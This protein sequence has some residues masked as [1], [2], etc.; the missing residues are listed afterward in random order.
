MLE[1][2]SRTR[3]SGYICPSPSDTSINSEKFPSAE[4][5]VLEYSKPDGVPSG[6]ISLDPDTGNVAGRAVWISEGQ[7]GQGFSY[8]QSRMFPKMSFETFFSCDKHHTDEIKIDRN[9]GVFVGMSR[10]SVILVSWSDP[11]L[12]KLRLDQFFLK[13]PERQ[14]HE[15]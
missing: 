9:N 14:S 6:Y 5:K 11:R 10:G 4:Y 7:P 8:L 3:R 12:T 13:C 1:F 15:K 2:F